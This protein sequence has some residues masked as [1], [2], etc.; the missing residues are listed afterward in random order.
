MWVSNSNS[1]FASDNAGGSLS[2][3]A[4]STTGPLGEGEEMGCLQVSFQQAGRYV[5]LFSWML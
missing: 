1:V 5:F 4:T 3:P 2:Q